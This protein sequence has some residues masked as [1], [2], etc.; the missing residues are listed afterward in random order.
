MEDGT[1]RELVDHKDETMN[2]KYNGHLKL[3]T[4]GLADNQVLIAE[5]ATRGDEFASKAAQ[6]I[7]K[8]PNFLKDGNNKTTSK[9]N[10]S[11]GRRS[12]TPS[13]PVTRGRTRRDGRTK[14][15]VGLTNLGNTCYMNSALQCIRSVEE[16]AFYFLRGR[17]K[18]ELNFDNPIGHGGSVAKVYADLL[19]NIYSNDA[20]VFA[21][22]AFKNT[23]G[24]AQPIF[25]G[26]GQQDSQ[27]FLSFLVDGLHEDLN[28]IH[29]KPYFE[30]P[31][32]TDEMVGN[33]EAIREL[34]EKYRDN[35]RARNDSIAMDLFNGFYKNT[36]VCPECEKVSI[37]FDPFSLLT[38]QLPFEQGFQHTI[39]FAPLKGLPFLIEVD[40]DKNSSIRQLKEYVSKRV[41]NLDW[42]KLM[43]AEIFSHKFYKTF[44]DKQTL[45]E[46]NIQPRDEL[47]L[48]EL[49]DVP[50]N[51]PSPKKKTAKF[52]SMLQIADSSDEEVPDGE[53]SLAN[54]LLVPVFHRSPP[55]KTSYS[56]NW[57]LVLW[58]SFIMI[59]PEEAQDEDIIL[60]K[61]LGRIDTMTTRDYLDEVVALN[62]QALES[63]NGSDTVIT[64]EEDASSTIDP[65]V[66]A[67]SVGSEDELVDVSMQDLAQSD[68]D[69][70]EKVDAK[71]RYTGSINE[72][73]R[74]LFELK[75]WTGGSEL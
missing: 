50:S 27:E 4:L 11:N 63:A 2:A 64:T 29:K 47:F 53:S 40:I 32:S 74:G 21:P 22:K 8:G 67:N 37:T 73:L 26:Y 68:S 36:M 33:K 24:R 3:G 1:S 15:S 61:V 19:E 14:G 43:C 58:P 10:S 13:G 17:Y 9:T 31:D 41:Q 12:P 30:N 25:S 39:T 20:A 49:E 52:R 42:K 6:N 28:R 62:D 56:K 18:D 70:S 7:K 57:E 48:F 44:E 23:I 38:L 16:L 35:H 75:Y 71:G 46:L 51:F 69:A 45:A 60:R 66:Q 55:K 34:G 72:S 65:T 54:H 5:E 59:T